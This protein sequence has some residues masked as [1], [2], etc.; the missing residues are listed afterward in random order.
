MGAG[1]GKSVAHEPGQPSQSEPSSLRPSAPAAQTGSHLFDLV[2][3]ALAPSFSQER[4]ESELKGI[5]E[6][7]GIQVGQLRAWTKQAAERALLIRRARPTRYVLAS[8]V[9]QSAAR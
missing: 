4:T 8:Q 1:E 9:E 2:W 7:H 6:A 3:P 5:A